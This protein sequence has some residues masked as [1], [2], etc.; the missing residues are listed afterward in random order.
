LF[1][2]FDSG[3]KQLPD[4]KIEMH[5]VYRMSV[6]TPDEC[7]FLQQKRALSQETK[8]SSITAKNNN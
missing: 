5:T 2:D 8:L 3:S 1:H 6:K 4:Y 7:R